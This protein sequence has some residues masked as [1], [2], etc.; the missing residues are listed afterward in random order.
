LIWS[1][2][3]GGRGGAGLDRHGRSSEVGCGSLVVEE[4]RMLM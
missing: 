3:L 4:K 2:I 1:I